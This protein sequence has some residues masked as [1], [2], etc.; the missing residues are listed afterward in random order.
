[1]EETIFSQIVMLMLLPMSI[2]PANKL[3]NISQ[4]KASNRGH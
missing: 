2:K 3:K 1:M 4:M